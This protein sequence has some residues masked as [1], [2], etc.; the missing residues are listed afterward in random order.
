MDT[1]DRRDR[2][3]ESRRPTRD[4]T[5]V[6]LMIPI[7]VGFGWLVLGAH[8][9]FR[10]GT[11]FLAIYDDYIWFVSGPRVQTATW[12]NETVSGVK[13]VHRVG[14]KDQFQWNQQWTAK[15]RS[16]WR[17]YGG[18][19]LAEGNTNSMTIREGVVASVSVVWLAVGN[20]GATR[21]LY[22]EAQ[23]KLG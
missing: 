22:A 5:N 1:D 3:I 8:F 21:V 13:H 9:S 17:W 6:F 18:T 23:G 4:A 20:S 11:T 15:C 7:L 19:L 16:A 2:L 14:H 10:H 12:W